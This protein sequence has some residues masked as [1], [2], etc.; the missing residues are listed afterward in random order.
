LSPELVLLLDN[1][2]RAVATLAGVGETVPNPHMLAQPFIRREAVLSSRIEGT[3]AS[4]SDVLAYEASGRKRSSGDVEEVRNYVVA[5]E[6]GIERLE[7]LPISFRLVNELHERLMTG[8]RGENKM[9]GHFRTTQVWNGAPGSHIQEA[10]FIPPPPERLR[11]LFFE[12]ESFVNE[13]HNLPPL[14]RC[15]LMHYQ[16]ETIHPYL[17]GNGRIGRL[18]ITLF[19]CASGV[20]TTPLLYLSAYFERD[21]QRYYDE[22]LNVSVTG[23]WERWLSYFLDGVYRESRDVLERIRRVR[24]LQEEWRELLLNRGEPSSGL[25]LLE[26]LF[27]HPVTTAPRVSRLLEISDPG[28]RRILDR[29]IDAGIVSRIGSSRPSLYVAQRLIEEIERPIEEG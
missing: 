26:D 11:D 29:L 13:S 5:L 23:D 25:R 28:A 3:L 10:R 15:A 6:Y 14:V 7:S 17:D 12:W 21:R 22:L 27:V 4:L 16:I 1:A 19:L 18:L 9:P 2:S 8:V 20:L 24:S